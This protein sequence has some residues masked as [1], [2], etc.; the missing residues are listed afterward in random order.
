MVDSPDVHDF[1]ELDSDRGGVDLSSVESSLRWTWIS[2]LLSAVLLL[3]IFVGTWSWTNSLEFETPIV[4]ESESAREALAELRRIPVGDV[5]PMVEGSARRWVMVSGF[6][7]PEPD[8]TWIESV[9]ARLVVEPIGATYSSIT[10]LL[11]PLLSEQKES[12]RLTLLSEAEE[13]TVVMEG[14]GQEVTLGL[15]GPG[16]HEVLLQCESLES[17]SDLGLGPDD[18]KLCVKLLSISV[19]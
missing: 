16:P 14:G 15:S 10:L 3:I 19:S 13:V 2:R 18:R 4:L 17:P 5:V 8:G 7:K 9:E 11:Y 12:R 6:A 1:S